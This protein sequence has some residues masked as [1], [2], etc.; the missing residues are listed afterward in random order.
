MEQLI[1]QTQLCFQK[2]VSS[3]LHKERGTIQQ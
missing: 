1:M 2:G 3:Q